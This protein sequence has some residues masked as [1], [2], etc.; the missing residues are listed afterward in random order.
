MRFSSAFFLALNSTQH[1]HFGTRKILPLKCFLKQEE[2][3]LFVEEIL[4][5]IFKLVK[6]RLTFLEQNIYLRRRLSHRIKA[7]KKQTYRLIYLI[8]IIHFYFS[9]TMTRKLKAYN[10]GEIN[11]DGSANHFNQTNPPHCHYHLRVFLDASS[12]PAE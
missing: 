9:T 12:S 4:N 1:W 10:F 6:I 5:V 7:R 11:V 3:Q 8:A 2:Q